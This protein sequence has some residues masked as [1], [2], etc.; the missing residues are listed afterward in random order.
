MKEAKDNHAFIAKLNSDENN[1]MFDELKLFDD[2]E[3]AA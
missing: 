3:A 2:Y 1:L